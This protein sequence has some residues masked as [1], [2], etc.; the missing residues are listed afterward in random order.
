[1]TIHPLRLALERKGKSFAYLMTKSEAGDFCELETGDSLIP[2]VMIYSR[3]KF[4]DVDA[5][6]WWAK[7]MADA[8]IIQL[9]AGGNLLQMFQR[10]AQEG[11]HV[12][13]TAPGVRN[14]ISA[15]NRLL[16]QV[17]QRVNVWLGLH[18]LPT[19]VCRSVARLGS[20]RSN[21]A[22]LSAAERK[23]RNKSTK[24]LIPRSDYE[25][26]PIHVIFLD[27]VEITGS[28]VERA[29]KKSLAAGAKSFHAVFG[30]QVEP[31]LA[32]ATPGI[33]HELNH[34]QVSF[35][36]DFLLQGILSHRDYQPVQR[37]LR[38]LLHPRNHAD[39]ATF[40]SEIPLE[41]LIRIYLGAMSNDYLRIQ[42]DPQTGE[43]LYRSSL[44][45]LREFLQ[46]QEVLNDQG[47]LS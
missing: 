20:G 3:M 11:E 34:F 6:A 37:A 28:T 19:M 17:G 41:N 43:P 4:G 16:W 26:F 23:G 5:I 14:V 31:E 42:P 47:L 46:D 38:L 25:D 45:T 10:A 33:E 30:I 13:L 24:S 27:D 18:G 2:A 8:M 12:Y 35:G 9:E 7:R 1:M 21:Y 22:E 32:R 29:Q 36:L 15:S 44:I 40:I 39:L